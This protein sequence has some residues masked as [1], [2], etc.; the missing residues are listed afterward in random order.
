M[1]VGS[2]LLLIYPII[3]DLLLIGIALGIFGFLTGKFHP[4]ILGIIERLNAGNTEES[5]E[6]VTLLSYLGFIWTYNYLDNLRFS[7]PTKARKL[8]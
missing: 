7:S 6:N 2:I 5:I 3:E 8:E 1:I 4:V